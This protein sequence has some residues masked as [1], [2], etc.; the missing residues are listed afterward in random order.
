MV[1]DTRAHRTI[2]AEDLLPEE[3][4]QYLKEPAHNPYRSTDGSAVQIDAKIAL[5]NCPV[6]S[7]AVAIVIPT[8][9]M[10]NQRVGVLFGQSS[11]IDRLN[12]RSIP[13]CILQAK[14][15]EILEDF[16]GDIMAEEYLTIDGELV[17][18]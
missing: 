8:S 6:S 18:L 16:W 2:I 4:R 15:E 11:C 14:G 1:F 3:F 9:Q 5:S 12:L 13:R 17:T 7:L 10:P